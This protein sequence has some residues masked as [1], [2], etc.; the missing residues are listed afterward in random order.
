MIFV[1]HQLASLS[2]YVLHHQYAPKYKKKAKK[3]KTMFL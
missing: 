3:I 1:K 2:A